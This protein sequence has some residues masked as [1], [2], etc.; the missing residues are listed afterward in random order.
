MLTL[1]L[2]NYDDSPVKHHRGDKCD[3]TTVSLQRIV[4]A[5]ARMNFS[6]AHVGIATPAQ[7]HQVRQ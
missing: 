4:F 7:A 1:T 6:S 3:M 2:L 5:S